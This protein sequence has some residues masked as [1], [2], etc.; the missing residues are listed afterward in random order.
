MA[1]AVSLVADRCLA[2]LCANW[3]GDGCACRV[4]GIEPERDTWA[5]FETDP[6]QWESPDSGESGESRG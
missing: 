1:R 3:T 5:D 2:E 6:N 4:F